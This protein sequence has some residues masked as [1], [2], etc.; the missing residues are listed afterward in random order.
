MEYL[1]PR[2]TSCFQSYVILKVKVSLLLFLERWDYN[3]IRINGNGGWVINWWKS[4]TKCSFGTRLR[5][6]WD[7]CESWTEWNAWNKEMKGS[8]EST[9]R[10]LPALISAN[11]VILHCSILGRSA[12]G[13]PPC[14]GGLTRDWSITGVHAWLYARIQGRRNCFRVKFISLLSRI[15]RLFEFSVF[16]FLTCNDNSTI[17]KIQTIFFFSWK[18]NYT[19]S[20]QLSRYFAFYK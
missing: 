3:R 1:S 14:H 13:D 2:I 19:C 9:H 16:F 12:A 20:L 7:K 10:T 18:I 17:V 4:V 5:T 11:F 6:K 15:E 8:F